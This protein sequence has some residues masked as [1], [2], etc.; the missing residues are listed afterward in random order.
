MENKWTI[1]N[2]VYLVNALVLALAFMTMG[3]K[4]A[5]AQD[6]Q[7]ATI[8]Q[9]RII[10]AQDSSRLATADPVDQQLARYS[11]RIPEMG[12]LR[13]Y[14]NKGVRFASQLAGLLGNDAANLDYAHDEKQRRDVV[15]LQLYR[16]AKMA[17]QDLPSATLFKLGKNSA[18]DHRFLCV[19]TLDT[20]PF[21]L[22]P[23]YATRFMTSV[24]LI[25][26]PP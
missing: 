14:G 21:Q 3:I 22:D 18:F 11:R 2:I 25:V 9:E 15:N 20:R 13:I 10:S 5:T 26:S 6:Q 23:D 16:I 24:M 8:P 12:F 7:A 4:A 17:E 1:G 19:I